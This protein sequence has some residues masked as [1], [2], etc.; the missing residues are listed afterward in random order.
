M[1]ILQ[2]NQLTDE[3]MSLSNDQF[4]QFLDD[5]LGKD[6][7]EL[8]RVQAIRDIPSLSS[9][10][11]NDLIEVFNFDITDLISLKA[12]LGFVSTDGSYHLRLGYK[13]SIERLLLLAKAKKDSTQRDDEMFDDTTRDDI[14]ERLV[15]CWMKSKNPSSQTEMPILLP[16]IA[17]IFSNLKKTKNRYSYDSSVQ[18]FALSLFILGGRNCY[19]FLR[20]NLPG[21]FPHSSNLESIIMQRRNANDWGWI[22][23]PVTSRLLAIKQVSICIFLRRLH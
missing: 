12:K 13:N 5:Y 23:I 2:I 18:Q 15:D 16:L 8:F 10:S 22:S 19:E 6:L 21:A 7:C 3:M 4:Y 1:D 9:L 17:N 20:L 14:L 11:L